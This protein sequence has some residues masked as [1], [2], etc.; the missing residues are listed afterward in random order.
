MPSLFRSLLYLYPAAY[1]QEYG[2]EMIGVLIEVKEQQRRRGPLALA[3]AYFRETAG[4]LQGALHEH[5][6]KVLFPQGLPNFSPRRFTMRSEF[7]FPK[8]TV[9]MMVLILLVVAIAID[10]AKSIQASVPPAATYVPPI[11]AEHF[12]IVGTFFVVF[13]LACGLAAIVWG[14]LFALNRSGL[15]RLSQLNPS[16]DSK[17]S[18]R[19]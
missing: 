16:A 4:L 15:Q 11:Q 8:S 1:R 19:S 17:S 13:L 14:V 3:V 7:R 5:T 18:G 9:T 10:K 6:R 2:E 12:T